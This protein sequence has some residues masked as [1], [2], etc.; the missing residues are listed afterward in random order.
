M[1]VYFTDPE[2]IAINSVV[3]GV[4]MNIAACG[5]ALACTAA[6]AAGV[7]GSAPNP[8]QV[9]L[10][11]A[12]AFSAPVT[13]MAPLASQGALIAAAGGTAPIL[14]APSAASAAAP[15]STLPSLSVYALPAPTGDPVKDLATLQAAVK[16]TR[17]DTIDGAAGGKRQVYTINGMLEIDRSLTIRNLEI[18]QLDADY[19]V[20]TIYAAGGGVPITLRLDN[21]KIERGPADSHSSGSVS[22]SAAIW[23]TNVKPEFSN[24]EVYGGGKGHGVHI[25]NAVGGHLSDVYVHDITWTPYPI[26]FSNAAFWGE[27]KL[28]TLQKQNNW[29][30]FTI[31]DFDG[32]AL[33]Q[34]RVE[35]Q[36]NGIV[37]DN[38]VGMKVVRPRIERLMTRF[39]DG[40]LYPY[41]SDGIS[42]VSGNDILIQDAKISH[43]A[44]GIDV[45]GFPA[46]SI[47]IAGAVVSDAPLFC[48]K[49]RGSYDSRPFTRISEAVHVT[50]RNSIGRRCGMAAFS[51][52]AGAEAYI[53]DTQAIDTGLGPDGQGTPGIGGVAAYRFFRSSALPVLEGQTA[54]IGLHIKNATISN[55]VS[56]YMETVFHSENNP[57]DKR[58]YAAA[59]NFTVSNP[60]D[61]AVTLSTNFTV[62]ENATTPVQTAT[63]AAAP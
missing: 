45:P 27:Y 5:G 53:E 30:A 18:K 20:R 28:S 15:A 62:V 50:V 63:L 22:D 52:A 56:K 42:I 40:Q 10:L 33:K 41:Q 48:F 1:R 21:L 17:F 58:T 3:L 36:V 57:A 25:I 16:N 4:A 8:K 32:K 61:A 12:Q 59:R 43:V 49:T 13:I 11:D 37:L 6:L 44:E 31:H 46:R 60:T 29:N 39:S 9:R 26:D 14:G 23:T 47:E 54:T 34:R 55:P 38:V 24:V 51:V 19:V 35:E 2:Y 7:A